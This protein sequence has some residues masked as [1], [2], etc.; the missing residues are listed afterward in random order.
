MIN[1]GDSDTIGTI[2]AGWYGA[3][4]GFDNVPQNLILKS[5]DL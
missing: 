1:I 5:N 3:L 4:Y 2:A